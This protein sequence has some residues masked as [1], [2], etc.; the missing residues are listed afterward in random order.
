MKIDSQLNLAGIAPE[1]SSNASRTRQAAVAPEAD[2][3]SSGLSVAVR[4][5]TASQQDG[6][7]VR[8]SRVEPLRQAVAS[9]Q[10]RVDAT[11]LAGSMMRELM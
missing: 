7:E 2:D 6:S 9:G 3:N 8:S 10:Y 11:A 4:S 5:L 1:P